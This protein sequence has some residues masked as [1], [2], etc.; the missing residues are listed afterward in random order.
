[1]VLSGR[2]LEDFQR[3]LAAWYAAERRELPWRGTRDAYRVWLSEVMLQQTRVAAVVEYYERFV[4]RFPTV[5]AL[6]RARSNEVMRLWAGLGYYSRARNLHA[7]AKEIVRRHGGRFPRTYEKIRELPGIGD[8]TAA[9]IASIAFDLPHAV[10]DG[11][12]AR[13]LARLFMLRGDLRTPTRWKELQRMADGLLPGRNEV[14]KQALR[15]VQ[16]KVT[17]GDWNQAM[18]ELG[19]TVCTPRAPRCDECPVA[20][21][22]AARAAGM[23]EAIPAV[24]K[25][26]ATEQVRLAALVLL[27]ASRRVLLTRN[28][29][30]YFAGMWHFP[31]M[32]GAWRPAQMRS[33]LLAACARLGLATGGEQAVHLPAVRHTVTFRDISI[34]PVL[35]RVGDVPPSENG[36]RKMRL[37]QLDSA[38]VSSATRK[39]ARVV[40]KHL[41]N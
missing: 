25:K 26:R 5:R 9:A 33:Q 19:A 29:N 23:A 4:R 27:D 36:F 11:N 1:M 13:V 6:A 3:R 16:G 17:P 34:E 39:I 28:E 30:P 8:Y 21:H 31:F 10:L 22:C 18:M 40:A 41:G 20:R 15:S 7:A 24:R 32:E 37:A 38:A 14:V 2:K 12:V 35:L